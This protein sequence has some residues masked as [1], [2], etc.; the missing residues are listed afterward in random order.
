M[1]VSQ[2]KAL[3]V[4]IVLATSV[5]VSETTEDARASVFS[6]ADLA[7]SRGLARIPSQ[8]PPWRTWDPPSLRLDPKRHVCGPPLRNYFAGMEKSGEERV[9]FPNGN[10]SCTL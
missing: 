8:I 2:P 1:Q 5:L 4:P 6:R 7:G 3:P 10:H 9:F